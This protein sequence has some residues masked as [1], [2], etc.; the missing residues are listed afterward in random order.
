MALLKCGLSCWAAFLSAVSLCDGWPDPS[1]SLGDSFFTCALCLMH[2]FNSYVFICTG[3]VFSAVKSLWNQDFKACWTLH[4]LNN[5]SP[6]PRVECALQA[7]G[8][9]AGGCA[10]HAEGTNPAASPR[11]FLT[12]EKREQT[13]PHLPLRS[14][15]LEGCFKERK[16]LTPTC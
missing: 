3:R 12:S 4:S 11:H 6:V 9:A 8:S 15:S 16:P 7:A 14:L 1:S 2:W 13:S 5:Q 10:Q